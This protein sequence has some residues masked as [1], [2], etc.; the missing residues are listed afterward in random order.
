[1]CV[2][3]L[4]L[5]DKIRMIELLRDM[6]VYIRSFFIRGILGGVIRIINEVILLCEGG[7]YDIIFIE[8]VGECD[9]LFYD[10]KML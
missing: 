4:F 8:I 10:N 7:G 3:G 9:L 2:L 1:M 5:G 6:N